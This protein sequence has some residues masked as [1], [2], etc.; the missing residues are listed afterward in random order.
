LR[1]INEKKN[2]VGFETS[3]S[4]R[5]RKRG[6]ELANQLNL[7]SLQKEKKRKKERKKERKMKF[8]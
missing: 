8:K 3:T 4:F 2:R 1:P 6:V 7:V 5:R